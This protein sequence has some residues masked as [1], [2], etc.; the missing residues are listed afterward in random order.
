MIIQVMI[1]KR[2]FGKSDNFIEQIFD[3]LKFA[4]RFAD[5]Q[6]GELMHGDFLRRNYQTSRIAFVNGKREVYYFGSDSL[7]IILKKYDSTP[8]T[9]KASQD[10]IPDSGP[11]EDQCQFS[12]K[13]NAQG[14]KIIE[15]NSNQII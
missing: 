4:C 5:Y 7:T 3:N 9:Q 13:E 8:T 15:G 1:F 6:I 14:Q 12:G 11:G 2:R 10:E